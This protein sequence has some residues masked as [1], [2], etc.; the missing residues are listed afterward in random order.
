[1]KQLVLVAL[2]TFCMNSLHAQKVFSFL[3]YPKDSIDALESSV[4]S[5]FDMRKELPSA[6]PGGEKE[7][8]NNWENLQTNFSSYLSEKEFAFGGDTKFFIRF[9]FNATGNIRSVGYR[10]KSQPDEALLKKFEHHLQ[11]FSSTY[12][13]GMTAIQPY[14]Q[15]GNVRYQ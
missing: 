1:M 3:T 2:F 4:I 10:F 15:C 12:N 9:Y 5:A 14:A 11:Q 7:V 8:L 6:F 13:F